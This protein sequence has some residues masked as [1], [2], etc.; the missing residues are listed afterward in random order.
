M[1][2]KRKI[3][4][5]LVSLAVISFIFIIVLSYF[6]L[7]KIQD[8]VLKSQVTELQNYW[9][10]KSKAKASI[11]ITNAITLSGNGAI[12]KALEENNRAIAIE[13][14]QCYVK[15]LSKY[16]KF[17]KVKIHIHTADV[18]SFVRLWKL[19]K[20]GDD[21]TGF[22]HSINYVK[23][24][25]I[26]IEAVE[27][28]RA[29]LVVRGIAPIME[30]EKYLGSVE[31]IQTYDTLVK[32]A[33]KFNKSF[34]IVMDNSLSNVA[35]FIKDRP[36][37]LGKY[38]VAVKNYD[39]QLEKELTTTTTTPKPY[40]FTKNYFVV[41]VPVYD[42]S[43]T[44]VGFA[45]IAK[46]KNL[47]ESIVNKAKTIIYILVG[48]FVLLDFI[49]FLILVY[50]LNKYI[51]SPIEE[52]KTEADE[53]SEGDGDLTKKVDVKS[54]DEIG[55]T[56]KAINKFINKVK[57]IISDLKG[58]SKDNVEISSEVKDGIKHIYSSVNQSFSHIESTNSIIQQSND[59]ILVSL[60]ELSN[61]KEHI[62]DSLPIVEESKNTIFE[63]LQKIEQNAQNELE[64]STKMQDL[65][66]NA[67][68]V[69]GVLDVISDIADQTNLLALN[70][71][72]EAARAGEHGRGFAVVADEVRNLAEKTQ[73]SLTE[74]NTT[75]SVIV[76]DIA[77]T[78]NDM[79]ENAKYVEELTN[80]ASEVGDKI[81]KMADILN[82]SIDIIAK[83]LKDYKL[84]QKDFEIISNSMNEIDSISKSNLSD[85]EK[86]EKMILKLDE[87]GDILDR[88][89]N[90]FKT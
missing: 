24:N 39:E 78:A 25:K 13:A 74:I 80:S 9:K 11:S 83:T 62:Q 58:V 84:N 86:M 38:K 30:H 49:F 16:T 55:Q 31:F 22:R 81:T 34:L 14:L 87:I 47:V 37:V 52:I 69:K 73:K 88:E 6:E 18:H 1:S 64:I 4:I 41:S 23:E 45:L 72:I 56:G 76:Q 82:E 65:A 67:E 20:Y 29:G 89:L 40:F 50:I 7:Q 36:I 32:A 27:V 28:G 48:G 46:K 15:T 63:L 43:K 61:K 68:N 26:P 54:D 44:L 35:T 19:N 42:F 17:K 60:R 90:K 57:I 3:Y 71:A 77:N 10:F 53:L 2:I 59:K 12:K 85:L 79:N 21:L 75:I 33:P 70:A 5:P 8:D 66:K 51:L